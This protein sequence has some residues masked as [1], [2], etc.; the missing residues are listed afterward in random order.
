MSRTGRD[1]AAV[2]ATLPCS[3]P[4]WVHLVVVRMLGEVVIEDVLSSCHR[5]VGFEIFFG[6]QATDSADAMSAHQEHMYQPKLYR[7]GWVMHGEEASRDGVEVSGLD[8]CRRVESVGV[9]QGNEDGMYSSTCRL[10]PSVSECTHIGS[11]VSGSTFAH[12]SLGDSR[13]GV[14]KPSVSSVSVS[15]TIPVHF[16]NEGDVSSLSQAD[17]TK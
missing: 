9:G 1:P 5:D 14:D 11:G 13:F 10:Y 12:W 17:N 4:V 6:K 2:A 15:L 7:D 8:S 3:H 16:C